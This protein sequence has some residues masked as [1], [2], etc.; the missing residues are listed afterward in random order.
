MKGE[1]LLNKI[2]Y[3]AGTRELTRRQLAQHPRLQRYLA[4]Q[5][6]AETGTMMTW[7]PDYDY[8]QYP[9]WVPYDAL[10]EW[11]DLYTQMNG[12]Y[13]RLGLGKESWQRDRFVV[14]IEVWREEPAANYMPNQGKMVMEWHQIW[15]RDFYTLEQAEAVFGETQNRLEPIVMEA[16]L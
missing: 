16:L 2:R 11:P 5:R 3:W 14:H 8:P 10:E 9:T 15:Q 7:P 13:Y 6:R 1:E 12:K 4:R